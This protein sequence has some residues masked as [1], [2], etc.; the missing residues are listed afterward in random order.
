M[1]EQSIKIMTRTA[2][3]LL[4]VLSSLFWL[5][6]QDSLQNFDYAKGGEYEIVDVRVEGAKFLDAKILVTLSSLAKGDKIKIPG[7][8]IPKAIKTLWKQKLFT[9]V[10]IVAEK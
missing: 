10:S 4:F 8:Q 7:E 3:S 2:M 5:H 1:K 9:N 6:A